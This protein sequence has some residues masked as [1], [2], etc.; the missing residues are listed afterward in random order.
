MILKTDYNLL[1][2][3]GLWNKNIF[4]PEWISRFLLPKEK[5]LTR[6]FLLNVDGLS[7]GLSRVSSDK[8]RIFVIGNK[9]NLVP[10]NT[11]EETFEIIQELAIK[12]ADYLPHTPVNAF[13][14]NF[15]FEEDSTNIDES[16]KRLLIINDFSR[17]IDFG[18]SIKSSQ[19]RHSL[20][21]DK[22]VLNILVTSDES[23]IIFDFNFHFDILNLSEFKEKISSN[24][25]LDLKKAALNIMKEVYFLELN[26]YSAK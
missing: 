23:K 16:L 11:Y 9:L 8:I 10:L 17:L 5:K 20:E 25:I 26:G 24:P 19:H 2:L 22:R 4:N 6:E 12:T 7:D 13:G 1:V 3:I 21:I 14:V 15:I 18:A